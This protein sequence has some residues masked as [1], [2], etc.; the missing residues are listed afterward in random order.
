[1]LKDMAQVYYRKFSS[2]FQCY[3]GTGSFCRSGVNFV[4]GAATRLSGI[5]SGIFVASIL[6]FFGKYAMYIPTS[7]LA[8]V[9]MVIAYGMVDKKEIGKIFRFGKS[10]LIALFITFLATVI[11][12]EVSWAVG[13]GV[14]A[15]IVLHLKNTDS[16]PV[17]L[18][19]GNENENEH[20]Q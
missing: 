13:V 19:I 3:A 20:W 14:V 18:L 11:L 17:K 1:M 7:G 10:D 8:G 6:L 9:I 16:V 12:P 15:T 2:F 5:L 4:S